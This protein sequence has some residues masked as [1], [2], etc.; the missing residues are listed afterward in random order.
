MADMHNRPCAPDHIMP[1]YMLPAKA[2]SSSMG[3]HG[4]RGQYI[5]GNVWRNGCSCHC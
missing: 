4:M 5:I 3:P 2:I 1:V